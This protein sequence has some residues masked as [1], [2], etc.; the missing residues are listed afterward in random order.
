MGEDAAI[1]SM[2]NGATD[3]VLKNKLERLVPAMKRAMREHDLDLKR[4]LAVAQLF[5]ANKELNLQNEEKKQRTVE[6][7]LAN[8]EL[9]KEKEKFRI[10]VDSSPIAMLLINRDG[11]I[12]L[13]NDKAEKLFQYDRT[14]LIGNKLEILIPERFHQ[15]HRT[16]RTSFFNSNVMHYAD[17]KKE[18]KGIKKNNSEIFVEISLNSIDTQEGQMIMA[19]I[20]DITQRKIHEANFIKQL[21]LEIKNKELERF[22]YIASH[23]LQEPLRTVSNYIQ[24]LEE[25]YAGLLD[26]NAYKHFQTINGATKRMSLLIKSLLDFSRLGQNS[27]LVLVDCKKLI[28]NV[29]ADLDHLIRTSNA[30]IVVSDMPTLNVYETE[31]C[32]VF[33]N[34]ITNAIKFRKKDTD[35]KIQICSERVNGTWRFSITDN[36]MGIAPAHFEDVF[37]IFKRLHSQ[38]EG[39]DG[40]GI[41]LANCKKIVLMHHGEIWIESKPGVGTTF[42]F[43]IPDLSV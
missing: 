31:L 17:S 5:V 22:A 39:Y 41:G 16:Q 34:L 43:T 29:M 20:I 35:P 4:E 10:L 40:N 24:I 21:E 13:V 14:E 12:I 6:L 11:N 32:E 1:N 28:N 27:K 19:S 18:F 25:D 33:Q 3:Y 9:L 2:L 23:D 37:V 38:K 15:K 7:L 36:G 26:D 30:E 42:Y 8:N